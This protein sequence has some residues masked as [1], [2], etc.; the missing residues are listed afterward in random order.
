[1]TW[2]AVGV[3]GAALVGDIASSMISSNAAQSAA[4]TQAQSANT[5]TQAQL[6]MFGQTQQN[7]AP[8]MGAGTNALTQLES[9]LGLIQPATAP[10]ATSSTGSTGA[11]GTAQAQPW[12]TSSGFGPSSA[13]FSPNVNISYSGDPV[14]AITQMY[15]NLLGRQPDPSGLSYWVGQAQRGVPLQNIASQIQ[16]SPEF[17]QD[18]VKRSSLTGAGQPAGQP[19]GQSTGVSGYVPGSGTPPA[20]SPLALPT[21]GT[22]IGGVAAPAYGSTIGGL[23]APQYFGAGQYQQSPGYQWQLGQGLEAV[24]NAASAGGGIDGGNT[25]KA[26]TGYAEGLANQDYQQAYSNYANN[27]NNA[28]SNYVNNYN[29]I[30]SGALNNANTSFNRLQTLAGSGQNAAAGL[31]ALGSQ[32]SSQVG[33]NIVGAGNAIAAGKIG[34][35]N[36]ITGGVNNLSQLAFLFGMNPNMFGGGGGSSGVI[37]NPGGFTFDNGYNSAF[38]GG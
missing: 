26:L 22:T 8:Y 21:Y 6:Q 36:A 11:P 16:S 25:L 23:V 33:S 19:T 28:Y 34:S 13:T 5:A 18:A 15:Q 2:V 14:S 32:V 7:L 17:S 38:G 20:G 29:N 31:G 3:G 1:M 4:N 35:A 9:Q 10:S 24:R 30:Y 27:Y 12:I 37:G